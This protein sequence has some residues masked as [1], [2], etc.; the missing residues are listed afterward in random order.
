MFGKFT[1][2]R[3][4]FN[5]GLFILFVAIPIMIVTITGCTLATPTPLPQNTDTPEPEVVDTSTPVPEDTSTP[6]P[7]DTSTPVPED[8]STPVSE[9]QETVTSVSGDPM[10]V[11]YETGQTYIRLPDGS[12]LILGLDT[13][14]EFI[15][16]FGLSPGVAQHEILLKSGVILVNSQL[17]EGAWFT[18]FNPDGHVARVTGS[19]MVVGY[20]ADTGEF[21]TDCVE[22][23]CE[24]GPDAQALFKLAADEQ[25][26]LDKD[27]NFQGPYDVDM[28]ELRETYGDKIPDMD[29]KATQACSD[30]QGQFPGTPCP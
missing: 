21:L 13:E 14:I 6:V 20:D 1:Q 29:A 17:P 12:E 2:Y 22:G 27:G 4:P 24:L 16:I 7:E 26:W 10:V 23:D 8:T 30:F 9:A 25:G 3:K 11:K 5:K 19:I 28:D 18:V 15:K